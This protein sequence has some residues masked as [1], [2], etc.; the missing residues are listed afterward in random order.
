VIVVNIVNAVN[1]AKTSRDGDAL[2]PFKGFLHN[3]SLRRNG[4]FGR[5]L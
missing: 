4:R 3:L 5:V 2:A 1:A